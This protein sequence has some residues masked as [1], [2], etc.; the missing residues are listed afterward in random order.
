MPAWKASLIN[1]FKNSTQYFGVH[2]HL[3]P[4]DTCPGTDSLDP[5]VEGILPSNLELLAVGLGQL[6]SCQ[7]MRRVRDF[8]LVL[9]PIA[10]NAYS[11][12]YCE[13]KN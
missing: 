13:S 7:P 2:I 4:H 10:A 1:I 12:D 8:Y 6:P 11:H 3:C 5:E 9:L